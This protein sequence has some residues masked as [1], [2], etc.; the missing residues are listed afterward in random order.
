[1]YVMNTHIKLKTIEKRCQ[2]RRIIGKPDLI[3]Y[4]FIYFFFIQLNNKYKVQH[5]AF[6][7]IQQKY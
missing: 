5:I 2:S 7:V 4:A 1:M 6:R 3:G